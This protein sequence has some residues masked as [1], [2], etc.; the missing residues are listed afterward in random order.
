MKA[1]TEQ[2]LYTLLWTAD[3][4][5][6]PTWRNL[7]DGFES[8]AWR[9]GLT[10][11]LAE[12]ERRKLIERR[13]GPTLAR[14]VR[15]TEAGRLAAIGGRDPLARWGRR[16]DGRWRLVL[17]DLPSHRG[18]LRKRLWRT[19][20]LQQQF[21]YLQNSVWIT[22]DPAD[23]VRSLLGG[24]SVEADAFVVFE[25]RPAGGETDADIVTAAWDFEAINHRYEQHQ[26]VLAA[27]PRAGPQL[28]TWA[29][30][31]N[32]AWRDALRIDPLLPAALLPRGYRGQTALAERK[33]AF[34]QLARHS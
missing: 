28:A 17:F 12:L 10:R 32:A 4:L 20:R 26:R 14:V 8:W 21:G 9:N 27:R 7:N 24:T 18:E 1:S 11:R 5:M 31:E 19:L 34:A 3:T 16:W 15:L 2:L 25:G 30:R 13:A 29:Q 33:R 6:R 22:P 23:S